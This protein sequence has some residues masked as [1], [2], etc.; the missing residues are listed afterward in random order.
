MS[1]AG[2]LSMFL[3]IGAAAVGFFMGPIGS[4]I[5]RRIAGR[6][7]AAETRVEIEEIDARIAGEVD[8]LRSRLVEIE[9][10]LDF[11]ERVLSHGG[12]GNQLTGG[13]RQ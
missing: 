1:G 11:A 7:Q 10:R 12:P 5:A 13:A 2:E 8:D 4:A 9:E 3:A 6:H